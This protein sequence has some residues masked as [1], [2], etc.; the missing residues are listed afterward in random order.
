MATVQFPTRLSKD[1]YSRAKV[2]YPNEEYAILL[3]RPR[4]GGNFRIE[5]LYFPTSRL[6]DQS[7]DRVD[8]QPGWFDTASEMAITDGMEVLGDI[9]SHCYDTVDEGA[10]DTT[11]S[12]ADWKWA[13][14][15][16]TVTAGKYRIMGIVRVQKSSTGTKTCHNRF[17]PAIELYRTIK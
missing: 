6:N 8:V 5:K 4:H 17:W 1:F 7:P 15:M 14:A 12:E 13:E 9:H 3:G 16:S 10:A 2:A 11:P